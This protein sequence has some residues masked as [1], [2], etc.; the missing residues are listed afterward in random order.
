MVIS[1]FG[2]I[3]RID[4]K[5]VRAAGR[6]TSGVKLLDLD[7]DYKGSHRRS[8]PTRRGQERARDR[9]PAAITHNKLAS[10]Q[11][12]SRFKARGRLFFSLHPSSKGN[13]TLRIFLNNDIER[14]I[15]QR[16]VEALLRMLFDENTD[17]VRPDFATET[18]L[19]DLKAGCPL[20]GKDV[21][22][23]IGWSH[24][25]SDVLAFHNASGGLMVFGIHDQSHK[26]TG[27]KV[28]LDGKIFNDQIRKF[29]SDRIWV[30]F[31]RVL[32]RSDQSY[33]GLAL[34]PPRGPSIERFHR[35]APGNRPSFYKGYSAIREHDST[36]IL[37]V[38]EADKLA[39]SIAVPLVN[40]TYIVDEPNFRIL[41]PEYNAFILR[42]EPC[43]EVERA[44]TDP[45]SSVAAITGIGG[46]GK[47]A[48]ATWAVLRAYERN[49]FNF[50]VSITAKDRELAPFGI[51][52]LVPKLT[53][54]ETLLDNI[55]DVLEFPELRNTD[56]SEREQAIRY[57]LE[58]S[59]GLLFVDNLET[60]DDARIV[61]FL[62]SLPVGV[63]AITTSRRSSVRVAIYPISVGS[64]TEQE[65]LALI[66]SYQ[67]NYGLTYIKDLNETERLNIAKSCD[68]LP[69]A[70]R[71][72]LGRSKSAI[73]AL[74]NAE[75]IIASNTKGEELLEFC[76]RRV[77]DSLDGTERSVLEVLSIF[78]RPLPTEAIVIGAA[79]TPQRVTDSIDDLLADSMIQRVFDPEQND[80]C[81]T[82]FPIARAFV[83]TNLNKQAG[84]A[85][86]MRS[87]MTDW[88]EAKD[89]SD[90]AERL[91]VRELRQGKGAAENAL[92]DIA[93][94]AEK[95]NDLNSAETM[96][97]RAL[98]R[99]QSSWKTAR[100]FAEFK[101]HKRRDTTGALRL[102][103]QA[104]SNA[105]RK[106]PDRALIFREWGMLLRDSGD[107][108]STDQ[109]I[110]KFEV[111]IQESPNDQIATHALASM[112]MRKGGYQR[113][114]EILPPLT[115]HPS[116]LTRKKT[117]PMLL[118]A[119][120]RTGD[121][122]GAARTKDMMLQDGIAN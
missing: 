122:M 29:L 68:Y 24:I 49:D 78:Q 7:S 28:K 15:R 81:Y 56:V 76:F 120:E 92:L 75:V 37:D 54:F 72:T 113:V 26:R 80:Y 55:A 41:H 60:V 109:A 6:S 121:L 34:I 83:N 74:S 9:H 110:D 51:R 115:R 101:R 108:Q 77:F 23:L 95:R 96:Y 88:F 1:Q 8:H 17:S 103:E 43:E 32:I 114:K 86:K 10:T 44:L 100:A 38:S 5:S 36:K 99:N 69:L 13:G 31:Y 25:A 4:T 91:T 3:I 27:L 89:V 40:K 107:P 46:T 52:S 66:N 50:I 67:N 87:V 57:L 119:Y 93:L 104:A 70:I 62:D 20:P 106:G 22:N 39:R 105:P 42:R 112:L 111:A 45:R 19:W 35:D 21:D 30:D 33:I 97:E 47:T 59:N 64:L 48:L 58:N 79:S 84:R 11:S 85:D 65:A 14:A 73:E 118:E 2:K 117:Y 63:R 116:F 94:A 90:P 16:N 82:A 71:W 53:T 18:D 12:T 98:A 102:Y 61:R